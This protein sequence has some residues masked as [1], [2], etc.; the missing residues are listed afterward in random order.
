MGADWNID[1][2]NKLASVG[3]G[4]L[5]FIDTVSQAEQAL[6][7][8]FHSRTGVVARNLRVELEPLDS[9]HISQVNG[10]ATSLSAGSVAIFPMANQ[11]LT[12]VEEQLV[13][14]LEFPSPA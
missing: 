2:L 10:I 5:H 3:G 6:H 1:L 11:L 13:L 9:A 8:A 4:S 12:N 14:R 7:E